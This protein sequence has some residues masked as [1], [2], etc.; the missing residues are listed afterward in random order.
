VIIAIVFLDLHDEDH[1]LFEFPVLV[2]PPSKNGA[3]FECFVSRRQN[4]LDDR[5][6]ITKITFTAYSNPRSIKT[7]FDRKISHQESADGRGIA[8]EMTYKK[9]RLD[10]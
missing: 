4:V 5:H 8:V 7:D 1:L 2:I 6:K 3:F 10:V 9:D